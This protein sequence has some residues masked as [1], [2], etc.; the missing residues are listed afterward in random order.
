MLRRE[1]AELDGIYYC[2]HHPQGTVGRYRRTC[3]CRKPKTGLGETAIAEL[4]IDVARSLVIGDK[5]S[6]LRFG[7]ALGLEPC[8]VRTGFGAVEEIKVREDCLS[9]VH[10]ACDALE[11]VGWA[12]ERDKG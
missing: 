1:G 11:A 2:P 4:G 8:L 10:V 3:S 7:K 6:D 5:T 12:I 9:G